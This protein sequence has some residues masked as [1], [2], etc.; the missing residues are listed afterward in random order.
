MKQSSYKHYHLNADGS[1]TYLG[2]VN[3]SYHAESDDRNK[4]A[5]TFAQSEEM[6]AKHFARQIAYEE[7][8]EHYNDSFLDDI[9]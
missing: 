3:Y 8:F 2:T 4:R 1:M 5:R 6:M 7:T 9:D